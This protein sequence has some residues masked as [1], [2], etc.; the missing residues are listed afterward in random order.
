MREFIEGALERKENVLVHCK[1][2]MSR[3]PAILCSYLMRKYGLT[4]DQAYEIL[5]QRRPVVGIN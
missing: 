5:K 3:S 4:F 1:G 2:G